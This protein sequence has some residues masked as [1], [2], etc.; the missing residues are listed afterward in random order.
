MDLLMLRQLRW[1]LKLLVTVLTR[2]ILLLMTQL[3]HVSISL[4]REDRRAAVY[5]TRKLLFWWF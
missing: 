5:A 1:E 2:E 3:V 4:T